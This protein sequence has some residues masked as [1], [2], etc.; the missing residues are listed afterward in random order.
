MN[1]IKNNRTKWVNIRLTEDELEKINKQFSNSVCQ[2]LSEYARKKLLDKP[3]VIRYRNQSFDDFVGEMILLRNELSA[4]GS[5]FNQTVKRLHTINNVS[6]INALVRDNEIHKEQF[7][8]KVDEIKEKINKF[9][10]K[11]SQESIAVKASPNH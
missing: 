5:N 3:V 6:E 7:F 1:E 4:I 10:D 11:W 8:K 9:S 2:K